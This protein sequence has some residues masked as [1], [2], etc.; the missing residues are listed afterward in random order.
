MP[1]HHAPLQA[2]VV[3]KSR[4]AYCRSEVGNAIGPC[5]H[6]PGRSG[7]FKF[8]QQGQGQRFFIVVAA[9]DD[10]AVCTENHD[11]G[12]GIRAFARKD[13]FLHLSGPCPAQMGYQNPVFQ[14][15]L[16]N[17]HADVHKFQRAVFRLGQQLGKHGCLA[18]I[19]HKEAV[20][21]LA[22]DGA[23]GKIGSFQHAIGGCQNLA[24]RIHESDP[25]KGGH[26]VLQSVHGDG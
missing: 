16:A 21:A 6:G 20:F 26:G 5:F 1:R 25:G 17:G 4:A 10:T 11:L 3:F 7:V 14:F 13:E 22:E 2:I 9:Q 18:Y 19:A 23:D 12:V 8:L 15:A 24:L